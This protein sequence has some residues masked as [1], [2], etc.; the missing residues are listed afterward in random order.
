M[1]DCFYTLLRRFLACL[2][3]FNAPMNCLLIAGGNRTLSLRYLDSMHRWRGILPLC[4]LQ[5]VIKI[6]ESRN[7][8][9][10]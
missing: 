1:S 8:W 2:H 10:I 6:T 7:Q 3:Y 9:D 4:F 5:A